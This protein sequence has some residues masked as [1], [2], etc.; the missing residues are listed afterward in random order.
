[1]SRASFT[2]SATSMSAQRLVE[3]HAVLLAGE[4]AGDLQAHALVAPRIDVGAPDVGVRDDLVDDAVK[5]EVAPD[6]EGL[7][8][9][10]LDAR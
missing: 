9:D 6:P 2:L 1:M 4:L 5:R 8:A 10:C 7:L 3:L